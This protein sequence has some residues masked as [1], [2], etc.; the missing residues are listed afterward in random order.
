M[1]QHFSKEIN[2]GNTGLIKSSDKYVVGWFNKK[3]GCY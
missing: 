3:V 2:C 1:P